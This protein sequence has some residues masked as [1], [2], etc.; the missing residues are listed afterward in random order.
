MVGNAFTVTVAVLI[1]P[2]LLV[3]VM[4][5]VPAA[6]PL[7]SPVFDTVATDVFEDTHGFEAAGVAEPVS[8]VVD[9]AHTLNVP[10]MVGSALTVT[11]AVI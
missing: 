2:L 5:A 9:P 8:C 10:V 4:T 3:Y 7:T 6:T 11:V 1:Q